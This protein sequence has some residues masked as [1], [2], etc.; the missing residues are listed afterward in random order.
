MV[1]SLIKKQAQM[2]FS[3]AAEAYD[4]WAGAQREAAEILVSM[5]PR[6]KIKNALDLGC[7]TGILTGLLQEKL[8]PEELI[9]LDFAPGM[10]R[11]CETKLRRAAF[12]CADIEEFE[13]IEK[14]SLITSSFTFQWIDNLRKVL[15]KCGKWLSRSGIF[16]FCLPVKGSL[17]ELFNSF[18]A[19]KAPFHDF[20]DEADVIDA[21]H[22]DKKIEIKDIKVYY[23]SPVEAV[24]SMK[25]I[26]ANYRSRAAVAGAQANMRR[27]LRE[28]EKTYCKENGK[29][30]LTY[31]VL[32]AVMKAKA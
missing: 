1:S 27:G 24:K 7:G 26:G 8:S 10:I 6:K 22:G 2:N 19:A 13:A 14:Y 4:L 18:G 3:G 32:F 20:P 29:C 28:Y 17:Y 15:K 11:H 30:P 31:R 23:K 5:I 12:I 16:A 9:G 21:L 25:K